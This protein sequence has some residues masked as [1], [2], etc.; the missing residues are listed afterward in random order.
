MLSLFSKSFFRRLLVILI[1]CQNQEMEIL[2]RPMFYVKATTTPGFLVSQ[3]VI[4][5]TPNLSKPVA[6]KL[7]G[8]KKLF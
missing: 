5:D 4:N 2:G 3:E 7:Q 8:I 6:K 1:N